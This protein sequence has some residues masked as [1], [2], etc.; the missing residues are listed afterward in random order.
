M[1]CLNGRSYLAGGPPAWHLY[2]HAA[3]G[4]PPRRPYLHPWPRET[5]RPGDAETETRR[6]MTRRR[7]R[8]ACRR[9]NRRGDNGASRRLRVEQI[10][11]PETRI[12]ELANI[13]IVELIDFG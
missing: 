3:V 13:L 2:G 1:A 9:R 7:P 10:G 5:R 8:S 12:R 11:E 6:R 4:P